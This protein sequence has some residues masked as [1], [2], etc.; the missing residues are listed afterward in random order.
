[1]LPESSLIEDQSMFK[2]SQMIESISL[3]MKGQ[4]MLG[5]VIQNRVN[6]LEGL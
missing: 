3:D 6:I 2:V 4:G 5:I 1:M